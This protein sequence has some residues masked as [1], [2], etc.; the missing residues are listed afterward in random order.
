VLKDEAD[1]RQ[2]SAEVARRGAAAVVAAGET[3]E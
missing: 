2:I 3:P 1:I